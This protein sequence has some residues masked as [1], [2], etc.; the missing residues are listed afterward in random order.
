MTKLDPAFK[1]LEKLIGT[2]DSKGRTL[3]ATEDNIFAKT[4][5]EP[6]LDG[7]YLKI[8]NEMTF[9]SD[10]AQHVHKSLEILAY[11]PKTGTYPTMAYSTLSQG[12]GEVIKYE[13]AT[14]ADGTIIHRGA[15]AIYRGTLSDDG[16]TLTGGWRPENNEDGRDEAS[17]DLT[18]TRVS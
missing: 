9:A 15:G 8:T 2:W 10:K 16:N 5:F 14:D 4:V 1:P 6:Y 18:M 7:K 17:Y 3:D 12:P 11:D 13:W